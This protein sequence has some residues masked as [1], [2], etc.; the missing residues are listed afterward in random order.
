M[1][2]CSG[3]IILGYPQITIS[4]GFIKSE[5]IDNNILLATEWNH[6]ETSLAYSQ[7]I[8]ILVAH[9]KGVSRGV[10]DRGVM[11]AFVYEMDLTETVWSIDNTFDGALKKWVD[12]CKKGNTNFSQQVI[13]KDGTPICPNCSTASKSVYLSKLTGVFSDIGSWRCP[14]KNCSYIE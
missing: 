7:G 5:K 13:K 2:Q 3:A 9:H 11:N 6:V 10:F 1:R 4:D 8:P 14:S 12:D